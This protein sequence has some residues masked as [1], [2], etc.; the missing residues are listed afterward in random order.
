MMLRVS[1]AFFLVFNFVLSEEHKCRDFTFNNCHF[2]PE[3]IID[4]LDLSSEQQCQFLCQ[5][6]QECQL[7]QYNKYQGYCYLLKQ[8]PDSYFNTCRKYGGP[9][10]PDINDCLN[11]VKEDECLQI[12]NSFCIPLGKLQFHA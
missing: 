3:A 8:T 6:T 12:R 2:D 7:F 4:A 11:E 9:S 1:L 10:Q 5:I